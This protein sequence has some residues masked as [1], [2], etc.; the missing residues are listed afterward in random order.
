M[1]NNKY[2]ENKKDI[3]VVEIVIT[4]TPF[5]KNLPNKLPD[6]K[7]SNGNNNITSNILL[8]RG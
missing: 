5:P 3:T 8:K 6:K 4:Q 7:P 2:D 1:L